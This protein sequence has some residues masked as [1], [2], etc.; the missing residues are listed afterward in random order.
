MLAQVLATAL[1]PG[2][3]EVQ[4]WQVE[5]ESSESGFS[6]GEES[7]GHGRPGDT[8]GAGLLALLLLLFLF[9]TAAQAAQV[10]SETQ[11]VEAQ[12]GGRHAAQ[13]YQGLWR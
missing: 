12:A 9:V 11:Q 2:W 7:G 3:Q 13:E 5:E 10:D 1:A 4:V 6:P 8:A